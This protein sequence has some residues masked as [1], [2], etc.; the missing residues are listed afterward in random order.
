MGK[1]DYKALDPEWSKS[2]SGDYNSYN[3]QCFARWNLTR[4]LSILRNLVCCMFFYIY[5]KACLYLFFFISWVTLKTKRAYLKRTCIPTAH[6]SPRMYLKCNQIFLGWYLYQSM[7]KY[8][9]S[10]K[11]R[12]ESLLIATRN[13]FDWKFKH[14]DINLQRY[15]LQR[16][17][18]G[19]INSFRIRYQKS[20]T[21]RHTME[22]QLNSREVMPSKDGGM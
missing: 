4:L 12:A 14:G 6:I 20:D 8:W 17:N 7:P 22:S 19:K 11:W 18:F 21:I 1:I 3:I 5:S 10:Q 13:G 15:G 9:T 2:D 16:Q